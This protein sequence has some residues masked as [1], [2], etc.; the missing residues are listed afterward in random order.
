MAMA[1]TTTA[2]LADT[3]GTR[4][5]PKEL[6]FCAGRLAAASPWLALL[7]CC[8]ARLRTRRPMCPPPLLGRRAQVLSPPS[9][10]ISSQVGQG[11]LK[12]KLHATSRPGKFKPFRG[13]VRK[14]K[15]STRRPKTKNNHRRPATPRPPVDERIAR[16]CHHVLY[17]SSWSPS[18]KN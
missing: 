6:A 16:D 2:A 12:G 4:N 9:I 11:G 8:A 18:L 10:T 17:S 3:T 15:N 5:E 14:E 13:S 1:T 7:L